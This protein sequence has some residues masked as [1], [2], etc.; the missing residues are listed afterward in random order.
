M[1]S[2]P[3]GRLEELCIS[4]GKIVYFSVFSFELF[5]YNP[6]CSCGHP[7]LGSRALQ[8]Y[9]LLHHPKTSEVGLGL[10]IN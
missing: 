4:L 3:L 8:Q 1:V 10:L 9:L 2:K 6:P 7:F 5:S